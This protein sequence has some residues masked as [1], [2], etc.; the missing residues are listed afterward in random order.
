MYNVADLV[1]MPS[2][3]DNLPNTVMES[4]SCA[5]PVVAF[6]IG[7]HSDLIDHKKNG[8]LALEKDASDFAEGINW[9]LNNKEISLSNNAREK[10]L[11]TFSYSVVVKRYIKLYKDILSNQI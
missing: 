1:L 2:L 9:V 7:G 11:N 5:V 4:L 10:V 6:D 3:E 8:Y